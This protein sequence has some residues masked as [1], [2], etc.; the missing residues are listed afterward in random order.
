MDGWR[1]IFVYITAK[2]MNEVMDV[3]LDGRSA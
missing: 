3:M 2:E 1:K